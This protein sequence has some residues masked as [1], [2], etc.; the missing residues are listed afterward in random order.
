MVQSEAFELLKASFTK[1]YTKKL[2]PNALNSELV[3]VLDM[4]QYIKYSVFCKTS[5]FNRYL[6]E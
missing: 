4:D 1:C 6:T 2:K 3:P 5:C